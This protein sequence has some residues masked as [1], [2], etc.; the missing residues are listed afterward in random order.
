MLRKIAYA[1][2]E[3][4]TVPDNLA[5]LILALVIKILGC[6][7]AAAMDIIQQRAIAVEELEEDKELLLSEEFESGVE[8]AD[9][10]DVRQYCVALEKE[11]QEEVALGAALKQVK[12]HLP[13]TVR[14]A[15]KVPENG[16]I[17][18]D[19]ARSLAPPDSL[20]SRDQFNGRWRAWCGK[21]LS[22]LSRSMS[23]GE[24]LERDIVLDLLRWQWKLHEKYEGPEGEK[25]WVTGLFP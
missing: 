19:V 6:P 1:K 8:Q 7:R 2:L 11:C 5:E 18:M 15:A 23:W 10:Q 14:R 16:L 22:R 20:I 25:C 3:M 24:R 21:G 12:Q 17:S 13:K 9:M 4:D